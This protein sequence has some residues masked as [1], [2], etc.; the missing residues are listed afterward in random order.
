MYYGLTLIEA[1]R[2]EEGKIEGAKAIELSPDDALMLY[3]AACFYATLGDKAVAVQTLRNAIAAG[4][5]FYDWIKRDSDL[6][7]IRNEPGYLEIMRG[8]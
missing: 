5:E 6:E 7:P 4:Y 1:G 3:N 8:K 2:I